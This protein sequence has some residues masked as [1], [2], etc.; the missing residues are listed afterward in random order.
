MPIPYEIDRFGYLD[1]FSWRRIAAR[2]E[3]QFASYVIR[4]PDILQ[5]G[6]DAARTAWNIAR[7]P[8]NLFS[9]SVSRPQ[10]RRRPHNKIPKQHIHSMFS[11]RF[12]RA[13]KKKIANP[14]SLTLH[15]EKGGIQTSDACAY[16][17]HGIGY[18][19]LWGCFWDQ[20]VVTLFRQAG[21]QVLQMNELVAKPIVLAPLASNHGRIILIYHLREDSALSEHQML[22]T[23]TTTYQDVSNNLRD[24][25]STQ[26]ADDLKLEH[27]HY[28]LHD[29]D[30]TAAPSDLSA[31]KHIASTINFD[32]MDFSFTWKSILNVQNRTPG[33]TTTDTNAESITANPLKGKSLLF[34]GTGVQ[35]KGA[36]TLASA[37]RDALFCDINSGVIA[38][39]GND[40]LVFSAN[41]RP[42]VNRPPSMQTFEN[43]KGQSSIHLNPGDYKTDKIVYTWKGPVNRFVAMLTIAFENPNVKQNLEFSN[44]RVFAMDKA[45]RTGAGSELIT[46]GYECN[47]YCSTNMKKSRMQ[48]IPLRSTIL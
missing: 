6:I 36:Y 19:T 23:N 32:G 5:Y 12:K 35:I 7:A 34:K 15:V 38:F 14:K 43:C 29:Q 2:Y 45:I 42:L 39:N 4:N 47:V 3:A 48:K 1:E 30:T 21:V 16:V 28:Q 37:K 25:T 20:T 46:L 13:R 26:P 9:T 44:C 22:L 41:E 40:V 10:N 11:G 18:R 24:W 33:S 8:P 31:Y 27:I 17:G